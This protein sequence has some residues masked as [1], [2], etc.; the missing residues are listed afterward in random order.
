[1]K[2]GLFDN[3][4][5]YMGPTEPFIV[6]RF[7]NI[8]LANCDY[9]TLAEGVPLSFEL[10][11]FV[12]IVMADRR[13]DIQVETEK[14]NQLIDSDSNVDVLLKIEKKNFIGVSPN[15]VVIVNI[16]SKTFACVPE[17]IPEYFHQ[18]QKI[19][20]L[21]NQRYPNNQLD[22]SAWSVVHYNREIPS[23]NDYS[24]TCSKFV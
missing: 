8:T 14:T 20:L 23:I 12:S 24:K 16:K 4:D 15:V 22:T 18:F 11:K 6:A 17:S 21:H 10:V 9:K 13:K 2:N 19:L 5:L 3:P 7:K 1:M